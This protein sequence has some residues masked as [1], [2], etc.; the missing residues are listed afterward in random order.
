MCSNPESTYDLES[1]HLLCEGGAYQSSGFRVQGS[2][3]RVRGQDSGYRVQGTGFR[4]QGLGRTSF[5]K[6]FMSSEPRIDLRS[7]ESETCSR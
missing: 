3:F 2:G 7:G 1:M 4:V 5:A 6:G